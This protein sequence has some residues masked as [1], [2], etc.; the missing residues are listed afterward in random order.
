MG[1][2]TGPIRLAIFNHKGG[3]GKTTLTIN[4]ASALAERGLGVLLVDSDPQCNLTSYLFDESVVDEFLAT[5]DKPDGVT[6]WSAVRPFLDGDGSKAGKVTPFVAGET[7]CLVVPGDI[8]LT[9]FELELADC[10]GNMFQRN[11]RAFRG[12]SLLHSIA[13]SIAAKYK[14]DY[15]FYDT[16]PNIG[17][18]NRSILLG[19]DYFIVPGACDLFSVRALKTLGATLVDWITDYSTAVLRAPP[20]VPLLTGRPKFLGYIPQGFRVYGNAM[21]SV[22]SK[23]HSRFVKQLREDIIQ[24]LRTLD[25]SLAPANLTG[26]KLG[27]VRNF[28]SL[29]QQAQGQGTP[30]WKVFGSP[31]Y[32]LD[33]ARAC[34]SKIA[35]GIVAETR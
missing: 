9:K 33:D 21:T 18:L 27:E 20:D 16:G 12:T 28:A 25:K 23:Y 13:D 3:V 5:S 24:P 22:A 14:I 32:Q 8:A 15:V 30:L 26:A 11:P 6:V 10:W 2:S 19:C 17:P 1:K 31:S 34:F 29:V 7:G 4:I 35:E